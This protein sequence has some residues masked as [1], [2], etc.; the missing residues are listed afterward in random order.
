MPIR[1]SAT[2][3]HGAVWGTKGVDASNLT[4]PA[5]VRSTRWCGLLVLVVGA[6]ALVGWTASDPIL[7][8]LR[9]SYIPMAPNTA[10]AFVVMGLGLMVVDSRGRSARGFACAGAVLVALLSV[11][12]LIELA[13]GLNLDVDEWF[14]HPVA[15]EGSGMAVVGKMSSFTAAAFL[16]AGTGLASLAGPSRREETGSLVGACGLIAGL[17]GLVF[18]LGYLFSPNAPLLYGTNSIPMALNTSLCFIGLG[19]GLITASGPLSFPL[20][21][22]SGSSVRARLLRVFL[23]LVV[24]TVGVVA[25]L[26]HLVTT[27]AGASSAAIS[28]AG[29]AVSTIFLFGVICERIA[30]RIGG[31]L[32][33]AEAELR[34]AHDELEVK[35]A[36]RTEELS[37]ANADLGRSLRESRAAHDALQAA[38]C[39]LKDAQCRM[40]QQAKMASLGQTAAGVA[41]EINNPL[42]YVTNNLAVLKREFSGLHDVLCLYQQAERTLA[43]YEHVLH[44]RIVELAEE[45]D[46]PF[47]LANLDGLMER[48]KGGLH[49]I[50]AGVRSTV[51]LMGTLAEAHNV[52]LETD[53]AQLPRLNCYPAK[54]N[55]VL[56]SLISNAIDA[57]PPGSRVVVTTRLVGLEVEVEVADSGS[58]IS[59]EIRDRVFDPFFTTKPIGKGTGLGLSIS[60]G[61]IKDHRGS[62]DF[63]SAPDQGTRFTFRLPASEALHP[64]E[65]L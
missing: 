20:M 5:Y 21:R 7:L 52:A 43:E 60:Y 63:E 39:A 45:V 14:Y 28:S 62:I 56:Q 11:L 19:A 8:G 1:R 59:D 50:N 29:L 30:R 64:C 46:L 23:P 34:Q 17:T 65:A 61:I 44:A 10:L 3:A 35:V 49:R 15:V 22:L 25:W 13:A 24:G 9:P 33:R 27:T 54:L 31:E 18:G 37:R 55:L 53:L 36:E 16:A 42:A 32:E 4:D 40:L 47:V 48:S 41:H 6:A 57:S 51:D 26:T 12:R 2:T 58:G 38:H